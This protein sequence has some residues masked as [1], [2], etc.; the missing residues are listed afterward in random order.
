MLYTVILS[1]NSVEVIRASS[2][3]ELV[4]VIRENSGD[5]LVLETIVKV[6][7]EKKEDASR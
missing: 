6:E 4:A 5:E 3:Q 7:E 1:N 2:V